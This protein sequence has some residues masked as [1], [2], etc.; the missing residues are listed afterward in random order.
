[1]PGQNFLLKSNFW[2]KTRAE[3]GSGGTEEAQP[4]LSK[5]IK[6]FNLKQRSKILNGSQVKL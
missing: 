4:L 5:K 6:L 2:A 1:L 3:H